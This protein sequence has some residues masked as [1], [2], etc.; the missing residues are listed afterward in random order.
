MQFKVAFIATAL[1][2]SASLVKSATI[3]GFFGADCTGGQ[4]PSAI[5]TGGICLT[6]GA[7]SVRSI[8]YSG[9]GSSINFYTSGGPHDNCSNGASLTRGPGSG[10]ATAPSG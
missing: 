10:C 9:V 8:S 5:G 6:L 2:A 1:F 3:V 4:T 7:N